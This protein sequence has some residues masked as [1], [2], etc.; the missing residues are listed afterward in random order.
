MTVRSTDRLSSLQY[1]A[2]SNSKLRYTSSP[3]RVASSLPSSKFFSHSSSDDDL[4]VLIS[5]SKPQL[6]FARHVERESDMSQVPRRCILLAC[7]CDPDNGHFDD[8]AQVPRQN[9]PISF[10]KPSAVGGF[11]FRCNP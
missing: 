6:P 5:S 3:S 11:T 8:F 2:E 9:R 10:W 7:A 1:H 4:L